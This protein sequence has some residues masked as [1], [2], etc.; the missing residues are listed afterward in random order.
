M[1]QLS[2]SIERYFGYLLG[3][4]LSVSAHFTPECVLR[5][6]KDV[7]TMLLPYNF[8]SNPYCLA[9]KATEAQRCILHQ[10]VTIAE[11]TRE[12]SLRECHAGVL[13]CIYGIFVK[14]SPVGYVSVSG[15]RGGGAGQ[16]GE[17]SAH[18]D[19]LLVSE[20]P[21][22]LTDTL[23]PPLVSMLEQLV[24][25]CSHNEPDEYNMISAYLAENHTNPDFD[26]LCKHF[27]RSRSYMSHKFKKMFGMSYSEY[28][29]ALRLEDAERLLIGTS[30]SVTEIAFNTGFGDVSY[31]IKLFKAR[32]GTSPHKYKAL[33]SAD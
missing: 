10:R 4:G 27:S 24:G 13:E 30:Q 7:W 22:S 21:I 26:N 28:C 16:A 12:C 19:A 5:F 25:K 1:Q 18:R 8:H 15:Y 11:C 29:N 17:R 9:V 14:D 6:P 20:P 23:I 2:R 33:I 3:E 31:F 32:Y